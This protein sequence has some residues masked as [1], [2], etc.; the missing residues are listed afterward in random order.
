MKR[1]VVLASVLV[2]GSIACDDRPSAKKLKQA[3][4]QYAAD[5]KAD[6]Q[7]RAR[8]QFKDISDR[9]D[10]LDHDVKSAHKNA[11]NEAQKRLTDLQQKRDAVR[12]KI[13]SVQTEGASA[14]DAAK[15]GV[16]AAVADLAKSYDEV[17]RSFDKP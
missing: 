3:T 14:A 7:G 9:I 16:D 5:V 8:A 10:A 13:D 1:W 6:Y 11:Q 15:K 4:E 17:K 12:K 2:L